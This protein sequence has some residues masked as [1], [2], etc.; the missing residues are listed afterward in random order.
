MAGPA[1]AKTNLKWLGSKGIQV[2][3]N[4]VYHAPMY[5]GQVS[6]PQLVEMIN[7]LRPQHVVITVGGGVQECLGHYLKSRLNYLPAIHCIGAAIGFLSGDQV[8]IPMWADKLYLGW[9]FRCVSAPER[10]IP[11]YWSARKLLHLLMRCRD[12][13]PV[14]AVAIGEESREAA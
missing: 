8:R 12:R 1:S 14:S 4:C 5:R 10:F 6:D 3:E 2:P 7:A 11:R 13:L 9:L